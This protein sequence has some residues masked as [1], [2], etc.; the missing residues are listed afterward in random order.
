LT[1]AAAVG[2]ITN[3]SGAKQAT[4]KSAIRSKVK[5]QNSKGKITRPKIA[6]HASYA[7][8]FDFLILTF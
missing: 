1:F 4:R 2:V 5:S 8:V 3:S 7:A 6:K